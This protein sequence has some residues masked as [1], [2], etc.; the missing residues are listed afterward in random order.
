VF[1]VIQGVI[2]RDTGA[3]H[4]FIDFCACLE[5]KHPSHL[6][7]TQDASFQDRGSFLGCGVVAE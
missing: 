4:K 3:L 6:R 5:P 7:T 1:E 2:K